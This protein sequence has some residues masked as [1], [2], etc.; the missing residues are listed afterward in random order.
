MTYW[1]NHNHKS[2]RQIR[3]YMFLVP[4]STF[5][6]NCGKKA[7]GMKTKIFRL[8]VS[9]SSEIVPLSIFLLLL[10][11]IARSLGI[12]AIDKRGKIR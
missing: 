9:M 1:P 8:K 10:L 6:K 3:Y 2:R 12:A 4:F 7:F 11:S 5:K